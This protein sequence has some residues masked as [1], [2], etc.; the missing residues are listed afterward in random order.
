MLNKIVR[1][2]TLIKEVV[3]NVIKIEERNKERERKREREKE[4]ER[5]KEVKQ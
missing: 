3:E 1:F 5:L 4:E 2:P